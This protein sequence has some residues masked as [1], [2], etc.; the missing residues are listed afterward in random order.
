[1]WIAIW[2]VGYDFRKKIRIP[3]LKKDFELKKIQ[4]DLEYIVWKVEEIYVHIM[5]KD[6][7]GNIV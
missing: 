7:Y 2:G 4:R 5:I 6:K 1:M 3:N